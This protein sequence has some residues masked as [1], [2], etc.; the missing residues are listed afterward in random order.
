M[1]KKVISALLASTMIVS[2]VACG[3]TGGDSSDTNSKSSGTTASSTAGGDE[4]KDTSSDSGSGDAAGS[5]DW[6]AAADEADDAVPGENDDRAFA[7]FDHV[8][9][10][11]YGYQI[12]P[13]DTTL[14]DGD[15]VDNNQYTRYLLDNYNIKVVCAKESAQFQIVIAAGGDIEL[16]VVIVAVSTIA[17]WIELS[18]IFSAGISQTGLF[19]PYLKRALPLLEI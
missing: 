19:S 6:V 5:G 18:D 7:K 15:S 17:E 13:K 3:S 8:V 14:P 9:E 12:D 16:G 2:L 1:K 4:A 10:V 11:H